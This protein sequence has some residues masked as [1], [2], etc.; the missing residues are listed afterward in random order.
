[1]RYVWTSL[2]LCN[3][4]NSDLNISVSSYLC[5]GLSTWF[6]VVSSQTG[7]ISSSTYSGIFLQICLLTLGGDLFPF[8]RQ[9]GGSFVA[10]GL[11]GRKQPLS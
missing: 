1:M 11:A 6:L 8:C 10:Q 4:T 2:V 7:A 9:S 5:T 3:S